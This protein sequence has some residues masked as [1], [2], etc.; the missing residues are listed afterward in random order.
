MRRKKINTALRSKKNTILLIVENSEKLFYTHYFKK[1]LKN[2]YFVDID[3][4]SS[5]IAGNCEITNGNK[6]STRIHSALSLDRYKAVFLMMDLKTKCHSSEQTHT[7]YVKLK[8]EYLPKFTID[9]EYRDRFYLF[10]VCNEI[11][12]WFLTIDNK[13]DNTNNVS[14]NHK[15][16]LKNFLNVKSELQIVQKMIVN[17]QSNKYILDIEKNI[18]FKYFID[19]LIAITKK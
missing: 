11:E 13:R 1:V 5:G 7:C 19:K 17:L 14:R 8:K 9:K 15:E 12:S 4:I 3:C 16:E 10:V 2:K 18:S 6:M